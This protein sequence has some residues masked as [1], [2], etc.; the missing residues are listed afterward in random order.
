MKKIKLKEIANIRT[1]LVLS[2]KKA[3][4]IDKKIEYKMLSL[5]SVK[6]ENID[7]ENLEFFESNEILKNDYLTKKDDIIIRL[8]EPIIINKIKKNEENLLISSLFAVIRDF[9]NIDSDYLYTFLCSKEFKRQI[10]KNISGTA[11]LSIKT[12]DLEE[13]EIV[14]PDLKTQKKISYLKKL[15]DKEL[16]IEKELIKQKEIYYNEIINNLI[17]G[18]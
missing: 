12:K 17:L 16:L 10:N 14:L 9:S 7:F 18:E 11:F 8:R 4:K 15:F 13:V 1:G 6:T 5:K 3:T 2:R